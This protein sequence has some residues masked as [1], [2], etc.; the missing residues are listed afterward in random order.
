MQLEQ[1]GVCQDNRVFVRANGGHYIDM[2]A[3][4][5]RWKAYGSATMYSVSLN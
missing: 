4:L 2:H 3:L 1:L 5:G